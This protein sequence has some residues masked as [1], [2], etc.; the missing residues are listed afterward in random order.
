MYTR[1]T[2]RTPHYSGVITFRGRIYI[3]ILGGT[4]GNKQVAV[5]TIFK[6]C[7]KPSLKNN[8][9]G[10]GILAYCITRNSGVLKELIFPAGCIG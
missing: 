8:N 4:V 2:L 6:T 3:Y 10:A 5:Q 7:F 1:T 9:S